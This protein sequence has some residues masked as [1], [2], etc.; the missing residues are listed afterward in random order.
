M[1]PN[2]FFVQRYLRDHNIDAMLAE[3]VNQAVERK[4]KDPAA[5]LAKF[6]SQYSRRNGEITNI[7]ARTVMNLDL[8]PVLEVTV[9]CFKNGGTQVAATTV[10]LLA[11]PA[12]PPVEGEEAAE[13]EGVKL[14]G[15]AALQALA[16]RINTD[17]RA[18]L[19]GSNVRTMRENDDTIR[20]LAD[21]VPPGLVSVALA[22]G[23]A[24]MVEKPLWLH[25]A[26]TVKAMSEEHSDHIGGG[27]EVTR[28]LGEDS[29]G[30][31]SLQESSAQD[32]N[33][34][35]EE[36]AVEVLPG[37]GVTLPTP[38]FP[39]IAAGD[40]VAGSKVRM[41]AFS[42]VGKR[43][44]PL[45]E[46]IANLI[47]VHR[48]LGG[49]LVE[50]HGGAAVALLS[51]LG[52]VLA[53][54]NGGAAVALLSSLG[55]VLAE[56]NGGAAVA[57]L[58]DGSY[59][60]GNLATA[61]DAIAAIQALGCRA[62][63]EAAELQFGEDAATEAAELVFGEDVSVSVNFGANSY[64]KAN[65]GDVGS[66]AYQP[67]GDTAIE[68][69]DW[70][71]W[72]DAML[73]K[74]P[75][76]DDWP[77]WIEAMLSKHPQANDWPWLDAMLSK[78]PQ[79]RC[80]IDACADEDFDTWDKVRKQIS[81]RGERVLLLG[82]DLYKEIS[83]REERVLLLGLDL[84]EDEADKLRQRVGKGWTEGAE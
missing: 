4:E 72:I 38:I 82:L 48:K 84:Y 27:V 49:V 23:A 25:M 83:G 5:S 11:I 28:G 64:F 61:A 34:P 30:T 78:H 67:E 55:A 54:K 29:E 53:E 24:A 9:E 79:V 1:A 20:D 58:P 26:E 2:V 47:A 10:G 8:Q 18:A 76:A 69:N 12:P 51:S 33:L 74:H 77:E 40:L 57:I 31:V 13:E 39:G 45:R 41:R 16:E 44:A 80:I 17:V 81:G 65:T 14:E 52:A 59:S 63:T 6:F 21:S 3:A 50:K 71:A 66:Y 62:A 75:Q 73:S 68:A 32:S 22:E 60:G 42:L 7:S 43:D 15:E 35:S 46:S 70:P 37:V 56:K 19:L 36:D